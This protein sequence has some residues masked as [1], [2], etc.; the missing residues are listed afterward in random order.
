[1]GGPSPHLPGFR[2]DFRVR[3]SLATVRATLR[4]RSV[5]VMGGGYTAEASV[6]DQRSR[7]LEQ[8]RLARRLRSSLES[9]LERSR[10]LPPG[11]EEARAVLRQRRDDIS[12]LVALTEAV[13][14]GYTLDSY[15][16]YSDNVRRRNEERSRRIESAG[17]VLR[18]HI[19]DMARE[20]RRAE[21]AEVRAAKRV[22]DRKAGKEASL[23]QTNEEKAAGGAETSAEKPP[24]PPLP[25]P[26]EKEVAGKK[27]LAL[28]PP[29][30]LV[31]AKA[32]KEFLQKLPP[33][34][35]FSAGGIMK[36]GWNRTLTQEGRGLGTQ[37]SQ[38]ED[39][40][41]T[42]FSV[43]GGQRFAGSQG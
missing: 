2:P 8:Y 39:A 27:P 19:R 24:A 40:S 23:I 12:E 5:C 25:E 17:T 34:K 31:A 22:A 21:R 29:P 9:A 14:G 7:L 32:M 6:P 20:R 4:D 18:S 37:S 11:S 16:T 26:L 38:G 15:R 41:D 10:V 3:S 1:M 43:G 36:G 30:V 35:K 33:P 42:E 28:K 13:R